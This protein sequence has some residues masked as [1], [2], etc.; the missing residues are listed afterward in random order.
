MT[1]RVFIRECVVF[2]CSPSWARAAAGWIGGATLALS[3]SH[4]ITLIER[5]GRGFPADFDATNQTC[6]SFDSQEDYNRGTA[7]V[8]TQMRQPPGSCAVVAGGGARN[9]KSE[10]SQSG[11]SIANGDTV[12]D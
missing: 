1:D 9:A 12:Y 5:M 10:I 3:I 2:G 7:E 6:R 8:R 11:S 4:K